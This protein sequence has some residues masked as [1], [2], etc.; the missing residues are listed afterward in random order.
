V[1]DFE[2][3]EWADGNTE[4]YDSIAENPWIRPSG[5][6]ALSTFSIDVDTASYALVR[7]FLV[8]EGRL[9]PKGAVRIEEMVNYFRYDIPGP[10][11]GDPF[12]VL[13]DAAAAP[14]EPRHRLVRIALKAREVPEAERPPSNLVFL[15]DVSGSMDEPKKLPLVQRSIRLLAERLRPEDRVAIVVYAGASGLVLP[16]TTGDRKAEIVAA[17]DGLRAGG[18]TNGGAGIELAYAIAREHF[19]PGGV[20]RV[21]LATDGDFNVGVT[22]QSELVDL[23]ERE[24][25][26]KVFLTALGFGV[27]NIKDSTLERLADK[28]NGIYAYIDRLSEAAKVLVE[29]AGGTLQTVA[30]DVKI[31][32]EW[33]P[34]HVAAYRIIGYENRMLAAQD[35]A[36]DQ[37]DAGEI[38]AGHTVTAFYEVVPA[39]EPVPG[40]P[41]DDLRYQSPPA[42]TGSPETLTVKLRFKEPEG[43]ASVLRER[44]FED[45]GLA[46]DAAPEDFRFAAAVA[47]FGLLLRESAHRGSANY[48]AVREIAASALGRDDGGRRAEFLSL[49]GK[50]ASLAK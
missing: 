44:P 2:V 31:Q 46:F 43:D 40:A 33:N 45:L 42:P 17:L 49:V 47:G 37:K 30:K 22:N 4:A 24:A 21:I 41:V 10:V 35:F 16:S 25:K 12:A 19:I 1:E 11:D 14:W 38:G 39:G 6:A 36:D 13:V 3:Q 48:A 50:A 15:L 28:G 32:V 5:E 23:I 26:S 29:E 27:G 18:S 8:Q 34:A 7:R 9:P 20:N